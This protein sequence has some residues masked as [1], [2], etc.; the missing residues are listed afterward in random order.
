MIQ[1]SVVESLLS[2]V[3]DVNTGY[4]DFLKAFDNIVYEIIEDRMENGD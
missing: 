2:Q 1:K 3:D 4:F